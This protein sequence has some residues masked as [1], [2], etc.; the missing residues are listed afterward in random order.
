MVLGIEQGKC[1]IYLENPAVAGKEVLK[2]TPQKDRGM[3][4]G[5]EHRPERA[6]D[7]QSWNNSNK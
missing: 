6:P 2:K 3:M 1:K 4:K 7:G 5:R